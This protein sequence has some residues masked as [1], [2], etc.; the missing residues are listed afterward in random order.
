MHAFKVE[1]MKKNLHSYFLKLQYNSTLNVGSGMDFTLTFD[2]I[3]GSATNNETL[4]SIFYE[5]TNH[6]V[7]MMQ[8]IDQIDQNRPKRLVPVVKCYELHVAR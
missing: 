3:H 5:V 1:G 2:W 7:T 6:N 8:K 4:K